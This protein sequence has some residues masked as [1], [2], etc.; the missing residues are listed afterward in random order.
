MHSVRILEQAEVADILAAAFA[1]N[2]LKAVDVAF[3]VSDGTLRAQVTV[4]EEPLAVR[5]VP[6]DGYVMDSMSQSL[7]R[8]MQERS[9]GI[10]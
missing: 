8:K 3:D 1:Y 7:L 6:D 2:R 5:D 4:E 9:S 10:T